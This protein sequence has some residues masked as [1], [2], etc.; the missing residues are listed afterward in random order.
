MQKTIDFLNPSKRL[1]EETADWLTRRANK[2]AANAASLAHICVVVPT[3]QSG[4][5]VRLALA[6]RFPNGLIPPM[7]VQPMRLV[8]P[9]DE[10]T[11]EATD[12]EVA[13]LFLKFTESRPK[14]R[15]ENGKVVELKEWAHLFR[16]E[17]FDDPDSLFSFLDQLSDIWNILGAGGML[18]RDVPGNEAAQ[19]VLAGATGD[20]AVRW[21][22]LAGLE[23]AFFEF[24]HE[25]GL[26]QRAESI[27]LAK[28]APKA[29]PGEIGEVVLPALADPVPV[30]YDV[31]KNQRGDLKVTV[32][33]HCDKSDQDKFNEWGRPRIEC[34][35]GDNRPKLRRLTDTD[36]V[37]AASD[38][39]LASK[40]ADDFPESDSGREIPSIGL[41]DENLFP[42]LAGAFLK[43]EYEIHDPARYRLSASSLG[44]IAER[45]IA[46]YDCGSAPWPW[47]D[48]VALLREYDVLRRLTTRKQDEDAV[49][50]APQA[51]EAAGA[52]AQTP[53][54]TDVLRGLDIYRNVAFP[55]VV[56]QDGNL[57]MECFDSSDE[58]GKADVE[59]AR[60]FAVAAHGLAGL[61]RDAKVASGN[62]ASFLRAALADIYRDVCMGTWT[63]MKAEDG[64]PVL[65]AGNQERER[66]DAEFS[67]AIEAMLGVLSQFDEETIRDSGLPDSLLTALLRKGLSKAV[68]SLEP[69]S[70]NVLMTEGWLELAWSAKSKIA[71]A[72]FN[73]G[74]VPETVTG[75]VFL[76]D[77]LRVALGLPS[78]DSRLA[79]DTFLL[80]SIV[81]SR[82][83]HCVR[84]YF[85]RTNNDGDIYRPSRLLFLV[86]D[87]DLPRR[88]ETLFGALP[89]DERRPAREV[90]KDWRPR[91]PLEMPSLP[92]RDEKTTEG[93]LSSSS[94]DD[95][96]ACPFAYL[97]KD[98]LKMERLKE[99]DELGADD[100]GTLVHAALEQ[101]ALQQLERSAMG[102]A[103]LSDERDI[104]GSFLQILQGLREGYGRSPSLK[105]R[106][107]LDSLEARL[108]NFAKIQAFWAGTSQNG[109]WRIV[110][111][112]ELE[113]LT[114]PFAGE[115]DPLLE[116]VWV[117]G[118]IDRID[119]KDGVGYRLIDYKTWDVRANAAK[120][121]L[122]SGD[123]ESRH[124][125]DLGLP[126]IPPARE[127]S[128]ERRFLT[129]QLPLYA[130]CLECAAEGELEVFTGP[131]PVPFAG[132]VIDY[133]YVVIGK[134]ASETVVFGSNC[135]QSC[136]TDN[137]EAQQRGKFI[138]SEY[139]AE[140]L[141]TARVAIRR[142][143]QGIFWPPGPGNSLRYD[144]KDILLDSPEKD[145]KD[146]DWVREQER[147]RAE[148][149]PAVMTEEGTEVAQ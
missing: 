142:I 112:P 56:P 127:N 9:A 92:S 80:H 69:D 83:D 90:A 122:S 17:A 120:H 81:A 43:R 149:L 148:A 28:T 110:A 140:A 121:I 16:P 108:V 57:P 60:R 47:D 82:G 53:T 137:F 146:S 38:G 129:T 118:K 117:K 35:T 119:Y 78:N 62:A 40:I 133:C 50:G 84:A 37:R 68:Y 143:R 141:E 88:V 100:F 64:E 73:E 21:D 138:L 109:G 55:S 7:V 93:R 72:G 1:V 19:K 4:R 114:R 97:L 30:L 103:Q 101:Y 44:S 116:D 87:A 145:L 71:L 94:I 136:A 34:W 61:V 132:N 49:D 76:P 14:R 13:A 66:E 126:L 48:F 27:H 144:L 18:M 2:D 45:L 79:R 123:D 46:L 39:K 51:A 12:A 105:I 31:L 3:A 104:R 89:S 20:E 130:R 124:A 77:L 125:R 25:H 42:E 111:K 58:H 98:V 95:W 128:S 85:S 134:T 67:A 107:Q 23:E 33:L 5:N 41:C 22:E 29:L 10:S 11:R 74:S 63:G 26:R 8:A 99:K 91:L 54:R 59:Y 139:S 113:F 65:Q 24:L 52:G 106:I 32:L 102:L 75:H 135:D 70:D 147:R 15:M 131:R 115:G 96:L 86:D 6:R 36:I